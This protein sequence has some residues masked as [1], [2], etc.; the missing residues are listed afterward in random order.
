MSK[1]V[2]YVFNT[3]FERQESVSYREQRTVVVVFIIVAA[4]TSLLLLAI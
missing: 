4:S 2:S 3:L 1:V